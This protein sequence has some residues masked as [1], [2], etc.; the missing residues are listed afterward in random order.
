MAQLVVIPLICDR[1]NGQQVECTKHLVKLRF[2][3]VQES[4]W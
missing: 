3:I 4:C 2:P 1:V